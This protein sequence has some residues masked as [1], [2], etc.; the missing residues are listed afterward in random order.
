MTRV[1]HNRIALTRLYGLVKVNPV[2]GFWG[3]IKAADNQG[4]HIK[5]SP[6]AYRT[7]YTQ[8][9]LKL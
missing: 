7:V 1:R 9:F 5:E 4:F 2:D 6:V 3:L 8:I